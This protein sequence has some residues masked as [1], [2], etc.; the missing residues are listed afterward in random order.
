MN[1]LGTSN[2]VTEAATDGDINMLKKYI[3]EKG[4]SVNS[5]DDDERTPLHWAAAYGETETVQFL[6]SL[7]DVDIDHQDDSGWTAL[8]SAVSAGH[9][10][11]VEVLLQR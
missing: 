5:T 9:V 3:L 10:P 11:V 1:R 7:P 2:S 4:I 8:M 6:L